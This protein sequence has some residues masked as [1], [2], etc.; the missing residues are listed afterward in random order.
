MMRPMIIVIGEW[1]MGSGEWGRIAGRIS[2][3][4][5]PYSL[6]PTPT[7]PLFPATQLERDGQVFVNRRVRAR[8]DVYADQFAD[9]A[10]RRRAGVGGGLYRRH[11]AAHYRGDE[12]AADLL[13]SDQADVR[14]LDHRVCRLDHR[15]QP[16]RLDHS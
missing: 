9:A 6:L 3:F 11:L 13:V 14:R 1:G 4:P 15:Y 5:T 12:T 10:R 2:F 8:D 16:F 7:S